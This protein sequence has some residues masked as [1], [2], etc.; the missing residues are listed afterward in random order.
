MNIIVNIWDHS[1]RLIKSNQE[2]EL[3]WDT[4]P[5]K[6]A[7]KEKEKEKVENSSIALGSIMRV[8]QWQWQLNSY[9]CESHLLPGLYDMNALE[10]GPFSS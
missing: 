3:L 6:T 8:W 1:I 9:H 5:T 10:F 4:H 7:K 2:E